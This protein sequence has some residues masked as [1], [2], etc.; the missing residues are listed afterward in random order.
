MRRMAPE[1]SS[2]SSWRTR[3]VGCGF[4]LALLAGCG[5]GSDYPEAEAIMN[6]PESESWTFAQLESEV[7]VVRTEGNVPHIYAANRKDLGFVL[8]FVTARD[9]YFMIH[10][11]RKLAKGELSSLLGQ[12]ALETDQEN[13]G[14]GSRYIAELILE[15]IDGELAEYVDAFAAGINAYIDE[16]RKGLV[17]PPSELSL[18][19]VLLGLDDEYDLMEPFDR[20]D[21]AAMVAVVFYNSSYETDDIGR[22]ATVAAL[23]TLFEGAAYQDLRRDGATKDMYQQIAPIHRRAGAPGFYGEQTQQKKLPGVALG[24]GMKAAVER[25]EERVQWRKDRQRRDPDT[26]W[27]SNSWAVA[28]SSSADGSSLMASDGHLGLWIPSGFHRSGINTSVF[29]G[30]DI[31]QLGLMLPGIPLVGIG[32]NG[33]VAWGQT[34]IQGDVTDWYRE[35]IQLDEDGVPIRSFFRGEWHDLVQVDER[36]VVADVEALDSPGRTEIW[37][38]WETFDGRWIAEIEG[39]E[40]LPH[41]TEG[42]GEEVVNLQGD[43][44]IPGDM[45]GDGKVTAISFDYTG[46]DAK[47]V[48]AAFDRFG[49]AKNVH[50]FMEASKGLVANSLNYSVTDSDGNAMYGAFQPFPCRTHLE[51]EADGEWAPGANPQLLLDGTKYGGFTIP[52]KDGLLDEASTV[53][54]ACVIPYSETPHAINPEQGYVVSTN[55]DPGGMTFDNSITNDKRYFGG[56]WA[57]GYRANTISQELEN[58]IDD[59]T[60]DI[61]KM[62]EIQA[63]I[64]SPLGH[65]LLDHMLAS[66]A[67]ASDLGESPVPP[68]DLRMAAIYNADA[69]AF[70]EVVARLSTWRDRGFKAKSGVKTFYNEPDDQDREDAVATMI[71]NAWMSRVISGVFNDEGL[72]GGVF[73]GSGTH[74]RLRVLMRF[75]DGRGSDNPLQLASFNNGTAESIFFDVLATPEVETSHEV[76]MMA[77]RDALEFLRSTPEAPEGQELEPGTGG[78]ATN[79][80]SA[81]LWGLRHQAEFESLLGDFIDG[82]EFASITDQFSIS[83]TQLPLEGDDERAAELKWFPRHGDNFGV[84][85]AN[86]GTSGTRFRHGSGPVWRM[87]VRLKGDEVEGVNVI[88]GGQSALKDSDYFSDQARLWLANGTTPMRFSVAQ[89][90]EYKE[91]KREIY[92]PAR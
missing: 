66:V 47:H 20:S 63:N 65:L 6:I 11:A 18:A 15:G 33:K 2:F 37:P 57:G 14:K 7:Q 23:P 24:P 91:A 77:L 58:A 73:R 13:R 48:L 69:S 67:Y 81:W 85:A 12:D 87:V 88:P 78:F 71:F 64:D 59:G 16:V 56:P 39:R 61:A 28:G 31:E 79:D 75:L 22:T 82:D 90:V 49:S 8:G 34:Q 10:L 36:Y 45:D 1:R 32:T 55:N 76:I 38:R 52:F 92:T 72:P 44:L 42:P 51:R 74:G 46:F 30:G 3:L 80:M 89:V 19:G 83:T 5:G 9:R 27:G 62:T 25:L 17:P 43:Y 35:E 21:V 86:P 54:D 60:A 41:Q 68:A 70:D 29:G 50:E 53:A 4:T 40:A 26:G 84:D